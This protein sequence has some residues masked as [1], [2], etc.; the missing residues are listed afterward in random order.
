LEDFNNLSQQN[1]NLLLPR[2]ANLDKQAGSIG[3][4]PSKQP[5]PINAGIQRV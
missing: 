3:I 1:E 4:R 2:D 5:D